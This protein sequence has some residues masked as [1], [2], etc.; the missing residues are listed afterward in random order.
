MWARWS[1]DSVIIKGDGGMGR[2]HVDQKR[3]EYIKYKIII[4]RR[5]D[6]VVTVQW[7]KTG[8]ERRNNYIWLVTYSSPF[9]KNKQN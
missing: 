6:A 9:L 3:G 8:T 2:G 5:S 4:L 1:K 7:V